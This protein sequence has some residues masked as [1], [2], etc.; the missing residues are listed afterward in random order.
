[1]N[2]FKSKHN[3]IELYN[4]IISI[5]REKFFYTEI[6]LDD[7]SITRLYLTFIHLG[8]I[9]KL[10]KKENFDKKQTQAIYDIFFKN[11]ELDLRQ[12]GHG[13]VSVNKKMKD[14]VKLFNEILIHCETWDNTDTNFKSK[15]LAKLFINKEKNNINLDKLLIYIDNFISNIE[16]MSLNLL[17]KGIINTKK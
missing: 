2:F 1:M 11:I 12:M 15:Y 10:L 17:L 3:Y 14:I 13:D 6:N 5:T 8:F 9:L 4:K 16:Y 7:T